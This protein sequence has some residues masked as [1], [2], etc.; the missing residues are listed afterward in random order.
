V[1]SLIKLIRQK[2]EKVSE[3][4]HERTEKD[5]PELA[6]RFVVDQCR[7]CVD[8]PK[9]FLFVTVAQEV[10]IPGESFKPSLIFVGKGVLSQTSQLKT[11]N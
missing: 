4:T 3:E 7:P 2:E 1:P 8:V 5:F 9:L 6:F 10:L 11:E